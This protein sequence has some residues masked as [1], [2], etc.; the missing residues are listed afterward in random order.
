ME[1]FRSAFTEIGTNSGGKKDIYL[2]VRYLSS[3]RLCVL[4][5]IANNLFEANN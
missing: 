4:V 2:V 3:S 5:K 1:G